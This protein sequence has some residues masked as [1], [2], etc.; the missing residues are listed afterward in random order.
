MAL[1]ASIPSPGTPS[2][3]MWNCP[4]R[5][6]H[7]TSRGA[8]T[9]W[10][11]RSTRWPVEVRGQ[12]AV[13]IGASTGG[14]SD[15]LLQHGAARV[16]AVDVGTGQLADSLRRDARIVNLE[17]SNARH[18]PALSPTPT[19]A[20]MDVAFVSARAILP[21]LAAAVEPGS[22]VLLLVKP[23][24]EAPREAV[25]SRGVVPDAIDRAA[26]IASVT[27]WAMKRRWRI[28]GVLRSPLRG[29][30]G[31]TEYLVWL[32]TP[33]VSAIDCAAEATK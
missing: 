16:Y 27:T 19:I 9:N 5:P 31:N 6:P 14:F 18:L 11:P 23:Q 4:S 32:R 28:G 12:I 2:P 13:D 8:A 30:A 29:P 3:P 26:T 15:C 20:V 25:D 33:K 21:S 22:D 24:F 7:A 1:V 10:P 17:K